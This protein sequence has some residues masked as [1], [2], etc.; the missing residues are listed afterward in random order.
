MEMVK[1]GKKLE[2]K[3]NKCSKEITVNLDGNDEKWAQKELKTHSYICPYCGFK[4][5]SFLE[6]VTF[7]WQDNSIEHMITMTEK[8]Q[9]AI[10]LTGK[11]YK[12]AYPLLV[13]MPRKITVYVRKKAHKCAL[14][15]YFKH[16]RFVFAHPYLKKFKK[17][18]LINIEVK[19]DSI[20]I[21]KIV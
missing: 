20:R 12:K 17:K 4:G 9:R 19:G 13:N 6:G 18:T 21:R 14:G 3:C 15:K 2:G 10:I 7:N 11:Q 16:N 8:R 5:G 1:N